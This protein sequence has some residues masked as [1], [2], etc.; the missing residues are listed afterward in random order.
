M[1]AGVSVDEERL[2]KMDFSIDYVNS[3]EVVVVNKEN[4]TVASIDDLDNKIVGVQQGNIADF[5]VKRTSKQRDKA[6]Y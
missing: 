4:P 5:W 1:A 6:L 2:E 3:T